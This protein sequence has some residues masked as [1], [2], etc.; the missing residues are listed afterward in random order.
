MDNKNTGLKTEANSIFAKIAGVMA[1]LLLFVFPLYVEDRYANILRAKYHFYYIVVLAALAII[2]I[3]AL[4]FMFIDMMEN[5]GA[6]TKE[7]LRSLSRGIGK[8]RSPFMKLL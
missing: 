8:R 7:S 5:G 3:M 4:I 6:G 2:L 1:F